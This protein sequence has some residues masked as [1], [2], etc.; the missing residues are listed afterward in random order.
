M[1]GG[2]GARPTGNCLKRGYAAGVGATDVTGRYKGSLEAALPVQIDLGY[3][4]E[5]RL[6]S[7]YT[8]RRV[9]AWYLYYCMY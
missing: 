3:D 7:R 5:S 6:R 9:T 4:L 2:S 1:R 8:L